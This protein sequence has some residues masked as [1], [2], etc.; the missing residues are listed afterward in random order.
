MLRRK[1]KGRGCGGRC[2]FK[3]VMECGYGL[4]HLLY[5]VITLLRGI[6]CGYVTILRWSF[7]VLPRSQIRQLW[8]YHRRWDDPLL[9]ASHIPQMHP[10]DFSHLCMEPPGSLSHESLFLVVPVF[11]WTSVLQPTKWPHLP[12]PE[13]FHKYSCSTR[14]TDLPVT[15]S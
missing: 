14:G 12:S 7:P 5:L 6:R 11:Y 8:L 13:T 15:E 3:E 1:R 9:G 10:P 4:C 2:A